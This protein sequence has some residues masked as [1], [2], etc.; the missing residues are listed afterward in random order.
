MADL[1]TVA[2]VR[3]FLGDSGSAD[4]DLLAR[5]V[6]SVSAR[7]ESYCRRVFASTAYAD[8]YL[9]SAGFSILTLANRPVTAVSAV[10][11][12]GVT[13]TASEYRLEG[14][15]GQLVRLSGGLVSYWAAGTRAVKVSYTAGYAATPKDVEDVATLEAAHAFQQS[16]HGGGR[17]GLASSQIGPGSGVYLVG[18]WLPGSLEVLRCYRR[19]V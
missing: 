8:E 5:L 9:D 12:Q 15:A 18:P 6:S 3:E 13:L 4:A 14:G 11:E 10:V 1:T 7:I 19:V 17:L 2:L 16:R